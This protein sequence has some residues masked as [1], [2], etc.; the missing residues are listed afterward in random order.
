MIRILSGDHVVVFVVE[1]NAILV[2]MPQCTAAREV[3]ETTAHAHDAAQVFVR[4]HDG[5]GFVFKRLALGERHGRLQRV[6]DLA[7]VPAQGAHVGAAPGV[8]ARRDGDADPAAGLALEA[9]EAV[10]PDTLAVRVCQAP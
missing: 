1:R 4:D 9:L 2:V 10:G 5:D 3:L 6:A 7:T 8:L